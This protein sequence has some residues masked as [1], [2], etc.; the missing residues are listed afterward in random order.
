MAH[1]FTSFYEFVKQGGV[2]ARAICYDDSLWDGIS[3]DGSKSKK[4][5]RYLELHGGSFTG[6]P[7]C[8]LSNLKWLS[9][10]SCQVEIEVANLCLEDLVI[11][12][13]SKSSICHKWV[14]WSLI[15]VK[16]F[17]DTLTSG[18][19]IMFVQPSFLKV[20]PTFVDGNQLESSESNKL[21]ELD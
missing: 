21:Q 3:S 9:W 10:H 7:E 13:L 18:F 1:A 12:D 19:Q 6:E 15:E 14:G 5:L 16:Y 4:S 20:S 17:I 8:S 2:E 11:L